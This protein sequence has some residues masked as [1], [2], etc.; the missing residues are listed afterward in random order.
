[1]VG[2]AARHHHQIGARGQRGVGMPDHGRLAPRDQL[3]LGRQVPLA[4]DAGKNQ[5]GGFHYSP[6]SFSTQRRTRSPLRKAK[7]ARSAAG[8]AVAATGAA[9][10]SPFSVQA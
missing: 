4:I 5:D 8:T 9:T 2:E 1:A 6:S 7:A 10:T 3:E